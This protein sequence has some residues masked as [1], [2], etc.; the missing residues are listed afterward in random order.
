M[1]SILPEM[2]KT[3]RQC[4]ATNA[5]GTVSARDVDGGTPIPGGN[6]V[7]T[8]RDAGVG[9]LD[10]SKRGTRSPGRSRGAGRQSCACGSWVSGY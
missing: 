10:F 2:G 4:G 7:E 1:L 8:G 9:A 6:C 5:L 3:L